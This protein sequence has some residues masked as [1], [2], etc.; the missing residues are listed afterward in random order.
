M[1]G[2]CR[3]VETPACIRMSNLLNCHYYA[4]IY[5]AIAN[6][7]LDS[8]RSTRVLASSAGSATDTYLYTLFGVELLSG[9]GTVNPFRFG[10][11]VGYFRDFANEMDIW[12]RRL[13]TING[14]WNSQDRIGVS[15]GDTNFTRFVGNNP[16]VR[17]DPSGLVI[18]IRPVDQPPNVWHVGSTTGEKSCCGGFD[19]YWTFELSGRP[20][21]TGR[22]YWIQY[23]E[24]DVVATPCSKSAVKGTVVKS[25]S[26]HIQFLEVWE[27]IAGGGEVDIPM[28]GGG[29]FDEKFGYDDQFGNAK[30]PCAHGSYHATGTLK[31]FCDSDLPY[32]GAN[33]LSRLGFRWPIGNAAYECKKH[34]G[35]LPC[36]DLVSRGQLPAWW[37]R[38]ADGPSVHSASAEW[39]C[40]NQSYLNRSTTTASP[41]NGI[42]DSKACP[43]T[44]GDYLA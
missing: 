32:P 25:L 22:A 23:V 35:L 30:W 11:Q 10:G 41:R 43:S 8:Q 6:S 28:P 37:G 1:L 12:W 44:T 42:K 29:V 7:A 19:A 36:V 31:Y 20:C 9:S 2:V 13:S 26:K 16:V 24:L 39:N 5:R 14:K 18:T 40:C 38:S 33:Q 4:G 15:A 21:G 17:V 34:A 3:F 27:D